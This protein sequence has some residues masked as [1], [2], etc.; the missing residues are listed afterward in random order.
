MALKLVDDMDKPMDSALL[1]LKS[2]LI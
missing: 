2:W 1:T